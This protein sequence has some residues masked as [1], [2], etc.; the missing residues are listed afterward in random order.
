MGD[1]NDRNVL[2]NSDG[3]VTLID[4]DSFFI[5]DPDTGRIYPSEVGV[6][7]Y[8]APEVLKGIVGAD[9]RNVNTDMFSL[10]VLIFKLLM[11]GFHP[12]AGTVPTRE[13]NTIE[14]NIRECISPYFGPKRNIVIRPRSKY[15]PNLNELPQDL[16]NLFDQAFNCEGLPR[17]SVMDFAKALEKYYH[18]TRQ[19]APPP[20][21]PCTFPN[22]ILELRD[23]EIKYRENRLGFTQ[24]SIVAHIDSV[25]YYMLKDAEAQGCSL[26]EVED[27]IVDIIID[28]LERLG[29]DREAIEKGYLHGIPELRRRILIKIFP[30]LAPSITPSPPPRRTPRAPPS[31]QP[32]QP[33]PT[34]SLDQQLLDA[35]KNGDLSKVIDLIKAGANVNVKDPTYGMTPL[36]YAVLGNRLDIVKYLIEN[37]ADINARDNTGKTPLHFAAKNGYLDIVKYLIENKA[38]INVKDNIGKTPLDY[39][40]ENGHKNVANYLRKIMKKQAPPQQRAASHDL[41]QDLLTVVSIAFSVGF[42]LFA[43][44]MQAL[45][46]SIFSV[47]LAVIAIVLKPRWYTTTWLIA[48]ILTIMAAATHGRQYSP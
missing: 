14:D 10:A 8:T 47:I 36:H 16:V 35:V 41:A 2:V 37:G 23:F 43:V 26:D 42:L 31:P 18:Q 40:E 13:S 46:I 29:I 20:K 27:L 22:G 44:G 28:T 34:I 38:D 48:V 17:P 11:N 3:F 1:L 19:K 30:K 25:I 32:S 6:G 24:T 33:P 15:A 12:F 45:S 7:E 4:T 21:I 39:A 9:K 5:R